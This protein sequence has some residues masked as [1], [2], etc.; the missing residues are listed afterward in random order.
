MR[1]VVS[2]LLAGV[3]ASV[4]VAAESTVGALLQSATEKACEIDGV[5]TK[6]PV[7]PAVLIFYADELGAA[8]AAGLQLDDLI[9]HVD[10]E[11]V[12][13]AE[14]ASNAFKSA[15]PGK[16]ISVMI[17]RP[18][19]RNYNVNWRRRSVKVTPTTYVEFLRAAVESEVSPN[20][21]ATIHRFHADPKG[22]AKRTGLDVQIV[23]TKDVVAPV[24]N[25]TYVGDLD[26]LFVRK[27]TFVTAT[28]RID[29]TPDL[30]SWK[31]HN[32][33]KTTWEWCSLIG[34][35]GS[36]ERESLDALAGF[37]LDSVVFHGDEF[38]HDEPTKV[39]ERSI[40]STSAWK[41]TGSVFSS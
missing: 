28:K 1:A 3:F 4:S 32:D 7:T 17:R 14:A 24:L 22:L 30:Q 40:T 39:Y 16:A 21:G 34:S 6:L 27:L 11:R 33:H 13:S 8:H 12:T 36:P 41:K 20:T 26:W 31:R 37:E 29:V 5:E 35:P 19:V 25:V 18:I 15:E 2:I 10:G 23:E 9:T 38:Y